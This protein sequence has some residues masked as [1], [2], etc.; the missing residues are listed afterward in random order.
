MPVRV[1]DWFNHENVCI[2]R[3]PLVYSLK[4]AE[5]R[6]EH[7]NDPAKIKP[8]LKGHD[9]QGFPEVEFL[10]ESDWRYGFDAALKNNLQIIKI[11]DSI[12]PD[13]PFIG[14]ESPVHLELPLYY[15][16]DWTPSSTKPIAKGQPLIMLLVPYGSTH[17][18]L[19]TLPVAA[20][21]NEPHT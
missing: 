9:I 7:T 3:G 1:E 13:N 18:R 14:N 21:G 12:M 19:T 8:F 6:L 10:P 2:T 11:I 16:P 20:V 5:E 4:I 17:L 15:L